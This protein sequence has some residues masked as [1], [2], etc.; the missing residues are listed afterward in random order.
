M[1][2]KFTVE[3][4]AVGSPNF[5]N[6]GFGAGSNGAGSYGVGIA[7]N[8]EDIYDQNRRR[9]AYICGFNS[10]LLTSQESGLQSEY[11]PHGQLIKFVAAK[12]RVPTYE[13]SDADKPS[14]ELRDFS[15]KLFLD[16]VLNKTARAG[17]IDYGTRPLAMLVGLPYK[18]RFDRGGHE[19]FEDQADAYFN[20]VHPTVGERGAGF[21]CSEGL[22]DC[23]TCT[24]RWLNS[25]NCGNRIHQA[26]ANGAE[27]DILHK[28][29]A[30]LK[31]SV[32]QTIRHANW[33]WSKIVTDI[34]QAK[35]DKPGK[36]GLDESD[37]HI[38][39]MIHQIA[40]DLQQTNAIIEASKQTGEVMAQATSNAFE[41]AMGRVFERVGLNGGTNADAG[42]RAENESLLQQNDELI[43]MLK[44]IAPALQQLPELLQRLENT[45]KAVN[46]LKGATLTDAKK[47]KASEAAGEDAAE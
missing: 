2:D 16:N 29:R 39:K 36:T 12:I 34:N 28:L 42:L 20:V 35:Q 47:K 18:E 25:E 6:F 21:V 10:I 41:S 37:H 31:E 43:G 27:A 23:P 9:L 22:A 17:Y 8:A 3:A 19:I 4:A 24:M 26:V 11:L 33:M 38:R 30:T 46:K 32:T 7:A 40:P 13:I 15:A 1:V 5:N 44:G 45:E 14:S